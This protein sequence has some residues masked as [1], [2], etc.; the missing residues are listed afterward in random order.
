MNDEDLPLVQSLQAGNDDALDELMAR[1]QA[2]LF[3]FIQRYVRNEADA[4]EITQET[5]VRAYFHIASFRPK[6]KFLTW[7]Y[8]IATNLCRDH[9][10]SRHHRNEGRTLSLDLDEDQRPPEP[11]SGGPDADEAVIRDEQLAA[12]EEAIDRLPHDLKTALLLTAV[13]GY[14]HSEAGERLGITPKSVETRVYRARR[15]LA[16]LLRGK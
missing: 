1:H 15:R 5:F 7:L 3:G 14:S 6:A 2:A 4:A 12:V 13:E 10:R 8:T 11:R 9:A 16:Q